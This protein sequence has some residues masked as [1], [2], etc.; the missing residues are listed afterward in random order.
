MENKIIF[1]NYYKSSLIFIIIIGFL[2]IDSKW[3]PIVSSTLFFL[4]LLDIIYK[5]AKNKTYSIFISISALIFISFSAFTAASYLSQ[6]LDELLNVNIEQYKPILI[7][8][9]I[10]VPANM[11]VHFIT[12]TALTYIKNNI[13]IITSIGANSIQIIIG[14]ILAISFFTY[15]DIGISN[16]NWGKFINSIQFYFK[17][18]FSS[19]KII[20]KIQILVA[21][22]NTISLAILSLFIAKLM[23]GDFMP[24]WYLLLPLSFIF[25]LVPVVGNV[26]INLII[27]IIAINVSIYFMIISIIYF[28]LMNKIELIIIGKILGHKTNLPFLMIA[29]SMFIGE[30]IFNSLLGILFGTIS[31][32]AMK[33]IMESF[34]LKEIINYKNNY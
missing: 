11:D 24:Y 8:L 33:S 32:L 28:F 23:T 22:L 26:I 10:K 9:G 5:Y 30:L 25:S 17:H 31:L 2:L 14:I 13:S 6:N 15:K 19:F 16:D 1:D 34:K 21:I 4:L 3:L 20:M 18:I 12:K 29:L 7:K 27:F